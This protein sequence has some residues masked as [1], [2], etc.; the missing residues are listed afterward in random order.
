MMSRDFFPKTP[1]GSRVGEIDDIVQIVVFLCEE[2]SRW[3]NGSVV[4]A[5][6]GV[7]SN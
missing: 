5:N 1:S 2:R 7:L 3:V 6:G 4:C